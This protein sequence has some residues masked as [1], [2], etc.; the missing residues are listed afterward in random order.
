MEGYLKKWINIVTRWQ[1]RYFILNDHILHY[2]EHQGGQSKGQIHL[3][4]AAIIL[5]PEDPLKIIINTG[6]NEIQVKASSVPEKIE[7][8]N[9]L[10][11]AKERSQETIPRDCIKEVNDILTD[12][13]VTQAAFDETLN[14]LVPK[15]ER[16]SKY[17]ELKQ[18]YKFIRNTLQG[19]SSLLVLQLLEVEKEKLQ[20]QQSDDQ[21]VFQ[22]FR[23]IT[24]GIDDFNRQSSS[25]DILESLKYEQPIQYK[26]LI[27][28]PVFQK[29]QFT[30]SQIRAAL[31]RSQDPNE[32]LKVW[33]FIKDMIGKDLSKLAVLVYFNEPLSMLQ[34]LAENLEYYQTLIEANQEQDQ[35]LR[36]C[37]VMGFGVSIRNHLILFL[38]P[39]GNV[40]I[41]LK[42]FNDKFSYNKCTTKVHNIIFANMYIEHI[43]DV[44]FNNY[45]TN[46]KGILTLSEN[47]KMVGTVYD[48]NGQEKYKL[49]GLWNDSLVAHNVQT[50]KETLV[51]RKYDL[52]Q[53]YKNYFFFTKFALNLNLLNIDLIKQLPCTDCRLR[54]DQLALEYGFIDLAADEKHRLEQKQRQRRKEM[55]IAG[56]QHLPQYFDLIKEPCTNEMIYKY[57]GNYWR[58]KGE[59][60]D[61]F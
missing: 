37:Y 4:V 26:N 51:W 39:I 13:W 59:G 48:S 58:K 47:H 40:Y 16:Q 5:V 9:A 29:I 31:P 54:P 27:N 57:K 15:L 18:N 30:N 50:G 8:V 20:S 34:R 6:T 44:V 2:C 45:T 21:T 22:S 10:K 12:I 7:W 23:N 25:I 42:Q 56:Q 53:D 46:D 19:I 55:Q 60:L 35:W 3:K 24:N 11:R 32:K 1:D 52:P 36:M 38:Q 17:V 61:L 49:K 43:G 28:N 33:S 41:K 14:I